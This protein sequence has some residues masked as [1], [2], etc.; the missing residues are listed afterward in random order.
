MKDLGLSVPNLVERLRDGDRKAF[1]Q[2][3]ALYRVSLYNYVH[4]LVK[5]RERV[6]DV[7]HETFVKVWNNIGSL[8]NSGSFGSWLFAIAR[9]EAL[10]DLRDR[11]SFQELTD[12]SSIESDGPLVDLINS[13]QSGQMKEL[14][15]A[16]RPAYRELIVLRV[17]EGLSYAELAH[18]TGLSLPAV[19]VH[20]FRARKALAKLYVEHF[21][22]HHE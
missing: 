4:W 5:G 15:D 11:K 8:N 3:Y 18:V 6:D 19:R 17:Y 22:D 20:L 21:G 16:L 2:I 7:V 1:G 12:E 13:E 9:N 14:L 10:A